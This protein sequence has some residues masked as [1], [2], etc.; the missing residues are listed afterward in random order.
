M[1]EKD[2]WRMF[3]ELRQKKKKLMREANPFINLKIPPPPLPPMR[4]RLMFQSRR[5]YRYWQK[6]RHLFQ[7]KTF[8]FTKPAEEQPN[9]T[10]NDDEQQKLADTFDQQLPEGIVDSPE[11]I[12][13]T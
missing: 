11:K 4:P 10:Q 7:G 3:H 12:Q 8:Q 5:K 9:P 13:E 6:R 2:K 1:Q